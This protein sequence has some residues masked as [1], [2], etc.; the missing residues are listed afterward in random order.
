VAALR[1]E[2]AE[3]QRSLPNSQ[4]TRESLIDKAH[5]LY[6]KYGWAAS[7]LKGLFAHLIPQ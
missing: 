3:L 2:I 7:L 1:D 5:R 4:P 6:E